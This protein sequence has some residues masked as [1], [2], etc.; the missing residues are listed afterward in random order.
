[1]SVLG[2]LEYSEDRGQTTPN[3]SAL[4]PLDGPPAWP[5]LLVVLALVVALGYWLHRRHDHASPDK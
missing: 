3:L 2:L 5:A 1:M 4:P